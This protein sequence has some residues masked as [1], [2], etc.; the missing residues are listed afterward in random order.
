MGGYSGTKGPGTKEE[1]EQALRNMNLSSSCYYKEDGGSS[2]STYTAPTG[3][4]PGAI[5]GAAIGNAIVDGFRQGMEN[6]RIEAEIRAREEAQRRAEEEEARQRAIRAAA[7]ANY[8]RNQQMRSALQA[9]PGAVTSTGSMTYRSADDMFGPKRQEELRAAY[10]K[11]KLRAD[12]YTSAMKALDFASSSELYDTYKASSI[13]Q[14]NEAINILLDN[15][16][17]LTADRFEAVSQL[18]P[19]SVGAAI[20]KL[21]GYGFNDPA[22]FGKMQALAAAR[23]KTGEMSKA[24]S[25]F[26]DVVNRARAD[27]S[28]KDS[29]IT[30]RTG[31]LEVLGAV[32]GVA[33]NNP[34]LGIGI[35]GFQLATNAGFA[36][37]LDKGIKEAD[38]RVEADL[39][40]QKDLRG[41]IEASVK[42]ASAAKTS[43]REAGGT[44]EPACPGSA[45]APQPVAAAN[46]PGLPTQAQAAAAPAPKRASPL[47]SAIGNPAVE[48]QMRERYG[49]DPQFLGADDA[50]TAAR[51]T[52]DAANARVAEL[53]KVRSDPN[54]PVNERNNAMMELRKDGGAYQQQ[55]AAAGAVRVAEIKRDEVA[56]EADARLEASAAAQ[57]GAGGLVLSEAEKAE[58]RDGPNGGQKTVQM[59]KSADQAGLQ[60]LGPAGPTSSQ[61]PKKNLTELKGQ[62]GTPRS[63]YDGG[64]GDEP[65][66]TVE[67]KAAPEVSVGSAIDNPKLE[68]DWRTKY[69]KDDHFPAADQAV[70]KA[71]KDVDD[72]QKLI[73]KY[74]N[75]P[76]NERMPMVNDFAAAQKTVAAGPGVIRSAEVARDDAA[77]EAQKKINR[78][79]NVTVTPPAIDSAVL[80]KEA[81]DAAN[82][83]NKKD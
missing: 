16:L 14:R 83:A 2:S 60:Q 9:R 12:S 63:I 76:V 81:I 48:S 40:R 11:A 34:T 23:G 28:I 33:Q 30:T 19:D 36:Y 38:G 58:L 54:A 1:C 26:V 59:G 49:A 51:K 29:D 22:V 70:I 45:S 6:A 73:E 62:R 17:G 69:A 57:P 32:L 77:R 46:A 8:A 27:Y 35:S 74:K 15:G 18:T 80:S 65:L 44:G 25:E 71:R 37:T 67:I 68:A 82:K 55:Q 56:G 61:D 47:G 31:K 13:E 64:N 42:E 43:W 66:Q 24:Y 53:E 72:A 79:I 21:Q 41:K 4:S 78:G 52:L 50:V 20:T 10:C 3:D 75:A 5:L 7:D 39:A